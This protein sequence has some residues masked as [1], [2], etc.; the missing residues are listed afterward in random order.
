MV[1]L[2]NDVIASDKPLEVLLLEKNKRLADVVA[3]LNVRISHKY[4]MC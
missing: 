4:A 2:Q 1:P 3:D